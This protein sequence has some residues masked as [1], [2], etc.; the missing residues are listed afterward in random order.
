VAAQLATELHPGDTILIFGDLGAGKTVFVKGLANALGISPD[1]VTS[2]TFTLVHEYVGG[3]MPLVHVDLYR[4]N[5]ADL[6]DIGLDPD[7][8]AAGVTA[9]EWPERLSR[10]MGAAFAVRITDHGGEER[11]IEIS[12]ER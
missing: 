12:R 2:P 9:I 3:R 8:S 11:V 5:E 4:L 6:D 1:A 10:Q 7:T